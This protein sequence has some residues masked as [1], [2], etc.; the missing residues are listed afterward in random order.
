MT[1]IERVAREWRHMLLLL[2]GV[3]TLMISPLFLMTGLFWGLLRG[4]CWGI[5]DA[6][7]DYSESFQRVLRDTKAAAVRIFNKALEE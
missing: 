2:A 7:L 3:F 1:M 4:M 6:C 5:E